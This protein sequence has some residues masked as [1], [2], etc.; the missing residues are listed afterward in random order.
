MAGVVHPMG[1]RRDGVIRA[2][3]DRADVYIYKPPWGILVVPGPCAKRIPLCQ[4][5]RRF[6]AVGKQ[7]HSS[8]TPSAK[9]RSE[10]IRDASYFKGKSG[11]QFFTSLIPVCVQRMTVIEHRSSVER[12]T[13]RVTAFPES[14]RAIARQMMRR[15][16]L[17]NQ[18]PAF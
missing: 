14:R 9:D 4:I 18:R 17:K 12:L 10:S 2:S 5:C 6:T 13:Y 8:V 11:D 15:T 16:R 3:R 1:A 7:V